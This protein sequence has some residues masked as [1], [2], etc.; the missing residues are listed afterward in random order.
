MLAGDASPELKVLVAKQLAWLNSTE[1]AP[2]VAKHVCRI[3]GPF[4]GVEGITEASRAE[5]LSDLAEVSSEVVARQIERCLDDVEDL[6]KV[7]GDGR[8]HLVW[9]LEKIAFRPD[10]FEDGARLLLRLAVAEDETWDNNATSQFKD[11]LPVL[12]GNTA[13]DGNA[14]LSVLDEAAETNDTRQRA[15]VVE[16]LIAGSGMDHFWRF[17]GPESHG[18]RPALEPWRPATDKEAAS[19][20]QGC[21]TGLAEFA[22][23]DDESGAIARTG[24]GRNLR[25]LGHVDASR[26]RRHD[27]GRARRGERTGGT[28]GSLRLW[29]ACRR[30]VCSPSAQKK[31][32]KED[33]R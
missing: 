3:G 32:D 9:A 8:R 10:S 23:R 27:Q 30:R 17:L 22:T 20:I 11:L 26:T 29:R 18:S 7:E 33:E 24:L 16:A 6:S 19:Y 28:V 13:A 25:G 4:D 5:V 21:V 2:E 31:S 15:I 12:L 14:R 1:V